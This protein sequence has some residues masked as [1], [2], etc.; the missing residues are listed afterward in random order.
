VRGLGGSAPTPLETGTEPTPGFFALSLFETI[1]WDLR[2]SDHSVHGHP[3]GPIR[4]LLAAKG[5]PTARALNAMRH[6]RRV[7]YAGVVI[8]RQRPSTASG[9]TFMTLEDE[10]G[11]VN[12]VVWP[13]VFEKYSLIGKTE[14]FLGVDGKL[15]VHQGVTHLI[16]ERLWKPGIEAPVRPQSRD[17]H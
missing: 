7:R 14:A 9:V 8:C 6:G 17:F 16:V 3:L 1:N 2:H 13:K 4:H 12:L 11:F 10:T 15:Q 5:L